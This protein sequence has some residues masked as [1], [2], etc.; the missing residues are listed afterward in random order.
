MLFPPLP[1]APSS[2]SPLLSSALQNKEFVCRGHD[3]ERLEAFQQRMLNEFPHAI[4]MQHVNQPDQTIYQADAQCILGKQGG[5]R[6]WVCDMRKVSGKL[7]H[8]KAPQLRLFI[9]F[10]FLFPPSRPI[11][12][13]HRPEL[14][15]LALTQ[16]SQYGG[17]LFI[18]LFIL[19]IHA[20]VWWQQMA[21]IM[22]GKCELMSQKALKDLR[23]V[24]LLNFILFLLS[25]PV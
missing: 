12:G 11:D 25:P 17:L 10:C 21:Y 19:I 24:Y 7:A 22:V 18:Y 15:F 6:V 5:K 23:S 14:R 2:S 1:F 20:N 3:Y 9:C 8:K 13:T 4:A 16:A